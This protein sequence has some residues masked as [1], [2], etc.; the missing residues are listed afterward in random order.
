M[1]RI[2]DNLSDRLNTEFANNVSGEPEYIGETAPGHF[3]SDAEWRI[4]KIIYDGS[5]I[6]IAIRFADGS[7]EFNKVW[8]NRS[9]YTYN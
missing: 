6:V 8:D 1:N 2:F 9:T 7:A 5:G 3:A 4:K